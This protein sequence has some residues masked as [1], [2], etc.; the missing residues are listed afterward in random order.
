MK[1]DQ[2]NWDCSH[3]FGMTDK[4]YRKGDERRF[5]SSWG[6]LSSWCE[7]I[8]CCKPTKRCLMSLPSIASNIVSTTQKAQE[9]ILVMLTH[10]YS[11]CKSSNAATWC[12]T[13][14]TATRPSVHLLKTT[15]KVYYIYEVRQL[16]RLKGR[17]VIV[18]PEL[19]QKHFVRLKMHQVHLWPV[20]SPR[21]HWESLHCSPRLLSGKGKYSLPFPTLFSGFGIT[22]SPLWKIL[23][24][25][26]WVWMLSSVTDWGIQHLTK[27]DAVGVWVNTEGL[28]GR[29]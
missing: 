3:S 2:A 13:T 9:S 8:W 23:C 18:P 24:R 7:C 6:L 26:T 19:V 1:C 21:P 15:L 12:W 29:G 11:I 16:L 25:R 5:S 27:F 20:L 17:G 10:D 4:I 22:T 28:R 14:S